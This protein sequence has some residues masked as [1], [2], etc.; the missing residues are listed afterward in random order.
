MMLFDALLDGE[1]L[2]FVHTEGVG[3]IEDIRQR[4]SSARGVVPTGIA[5]KNTRETYC[6]M[7]AG[8]SA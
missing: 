4:Q 7:P 1:T 5:E 2:C 8:C 6:M 3:C